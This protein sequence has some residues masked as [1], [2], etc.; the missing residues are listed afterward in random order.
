MPSP[1]ENEPLSTTYGTPASWPSASLFLPPHKPKNGP[2]LGSNV[3]TSGIERS[4]HP[5]GRS[6]RV[7]KAARTVS[8]E[9]VGG[10]VEVVVEISAGIEVV[11][12]S[13]LSDEA[14]AHPEMA[15]VAARPISHGDGFI[16]VLLPLGHLW[17]ANEPLL[18][19][20]W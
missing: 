3:R 20:L 11:V 19:H 6:S 2:S 15:T 9:Y 14:P 16:R 4:V 7:G 18:Q 17:S 12:A 5:A 1:D 8:G 13:V 10:I